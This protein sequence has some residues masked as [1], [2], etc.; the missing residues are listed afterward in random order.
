MGTHS[1]VELR[2]RR[3]TWA[4]YGWGVALTVGILVVWGMVLWGQ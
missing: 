2:V 1:T 3:L 4:V